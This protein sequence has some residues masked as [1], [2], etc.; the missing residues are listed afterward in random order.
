LKFL[1]WGVTFGVCAGGLALDYFTKRLVEDHMPVGH[2]Y[3][4]LP[5]LSLQ[6]TQNTGAAFGLF[7]GQ[8]WLFI[9][10][11]AAAVIAVLAFVHIEKHAISAGVAGGLVLAGALGNNLVDRLRQGYVTDFI[12]LPHWPNFNVADIMLVVGLVLIVLLVLRSLPPSE[13]R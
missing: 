13:E 11:T 4:I 7:A 8:A 2:V 10:A 9:A 3:E 5:F 1:R 6:R 12:K